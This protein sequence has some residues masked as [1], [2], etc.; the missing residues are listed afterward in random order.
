MT[1]AIVG[2]QDT[3]PEPVITVVSQAI[4][5]IK[6]LMV[7]DEIYDWRVIED[8]GRIFRRF[9]RTLPLEAWIVA[10][11]RSDPGARRRITCP[12]ALDPKAFGQAS[13]ETVEAE[14]RSVVAE[15][16]AAN[17]A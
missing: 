8:D 15:L 17:P 2:P 5:A 13:Q 9:T 4:D 14:I 1:A 3:I 16:N 10:S 6:A 7:E 11:S 12:V